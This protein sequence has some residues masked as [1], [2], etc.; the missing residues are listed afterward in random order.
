MSV[1]TWLQQGLQEELLHSTWDF[2]K[3]A[4]TMPR[5][6]EQPHREMLSELDALDLDY[7]YTTQRRKLYLAPRF[8]FKTTSVINWLGRQLYKNPDAK[9][10]IVRATRELAEGMLTELKDSMTKNPTLVAAF[11]DVSKG[12]S[13]WS[14]TE[15]TL[16][17]RTKADKDPSVRTSGL[18]VSTTGMH[19]DIIVADDLVVYEN[20]DS[21]AEMERALGLIHSFMPLL[22][23][24][25]ILLVSGTIWSPIDCYVKLMEENKRMREAGKQP[26]FMEYRR[27]VYYTDG[28]GNKQLFFPKELTEAFIQ[29]QKETLPPRWFYAWYYN[30]PYVTGLKPFDTIKMFDGSHEAGA[31]HYLELKDYPGIRIPV[32]TV[33][34]LDTAMTAT[35]RSSRF[36]LCVTCKDYEDTWY[37][38]EA[39]ELH[40]L[41]SDVT[42]KIQEVL[43]VYE[44]EVLMIEAQ[45]VDVEMVSR[46]QQFISDNY[47]QTRIVPYSALQDELR[48]H[49]SKARRIEALEPRNKAGKLKLRRNYCSDLLRQM[50]MYPSND[51]NDVIDSMAMTHVAMRYAT[52]PAPTYEEALR[53]GENEGMEVAD[54]WRSR[55]L[56]IQASSGIGVVEPEILKPD[57]DYRHRKGMWTGPNLTR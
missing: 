48:G 50:D 49:R 10:L 6:K 30:Q 39:D 14:L 52:E 27:E 55:V 4:N 3:G 43:L 38:L 8:T 56:E 7:N 18:S 13:K 44:P 21:P 22:P 45:Q 20:C 19:P 42:L 2:C 24:W 32:T 15:I 36:G 23:P 37:V 12:T 57:R 29:Q 25:G 54:A 51:R 28:Y 1:E 31:I 35:A 33:A 34:T 26:Q 11:G 16:G 47:L 46:I 9:A 5:M 40:M 53:P 41:P 17:T